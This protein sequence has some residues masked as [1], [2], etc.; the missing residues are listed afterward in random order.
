MGMGTKV[1]E[2]FCIL[3]STVLYGKVRVNY[4]Y[5]RNRGPVITKG[6]NIFW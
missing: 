3:K 4:R 1:Q 5:I 6:L 2:C